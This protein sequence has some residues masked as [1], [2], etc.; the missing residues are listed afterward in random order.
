MPEVPLRYRAFISY[1][2]ANRR[3]AVRLHRD[4]ER[5]SIPAHLRTPD[6]PAHLRP[7]F[8]DRDFLGPS[9]D[10]SASIRE[11][12]EQ[13]PTLIVVSSPAAASSGWVARE[14]EYFIERHGPAAV[15][16][17]IVDGEPNAADPALE[18]LPRPL[19][20][21][22]CGR[23]VLAADARPTADGWRNAVVKIA[24]GLSGLPFAELANREQQRA[25]RQALTWAAAGILLATIFGALALHSHR[26]AHQARQAAHRAEL[27]ANY[28]QGVLWQFS[29]RAGGNVAQHALLSIIDASAHPDRL[30]VLHNEPDALLHVRRSLARSYLEL[31]AADRARPLLEE[32]VALATELYGPTHRLTLSN[33]HDLGNTLNALGD[34]E[35]GAR[36]LRQL[37]DLAFLTEGERSEDYLRAMTNLANSLSYS[38]RNNEARELFTRVYEIGHTF[39]PSDCAGFHNARRNY[40]II[41]LNDGKNAEALAVL[42]ELYQDQLKSHGPDYL[43]TVETHPFLADVHHAL[44]NL[45]ETLF[46]LEQTVEGLTRIH[47]PREYRVRLA[48]ER[49]VGLL[50]EV[51]RHEEAEAFIRRY[52]DVFADQPD[53]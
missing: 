21:Q 8:L 3:A 29:P 14:V 40:A 2:H 7:I 50:H 48:A 52:P 23:D 36:I 38:G 53:S 13:S 22:H 44:G 17:F 41:L 30:L 35:A 6:T 5:Y 42:E 34:H 19:Q 49:T 24:A 51:G 11:A 4:L 12:L 37:L 47:G 26:Q 9:P 15:L 33:L 25:R 27:I 18:A 16:C 43:G 20:L 32:N 28:L 46:H 39:M 10:L 31:N 45:E 1:C